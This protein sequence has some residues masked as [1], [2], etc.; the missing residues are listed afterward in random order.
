MTAMKIVRA[1]GTDE[2]HRRRTETASEIYEQLTRRPIGPV[3]IFEDEQRRYA[4][5]QPLEYA[6]E[7]FEQCAGDDALSSRRVELGQQR[8]ELVPAGPDHRLEGCI[9]ER[10]MKRAQHLD[11][12]T[13]WQ[14]SVDEV[15]AIAD[16]HA[17]RLGDARDELRQ[18]SRFADTRLAGHEYGLRALVDDRRFPDLLEPR[19]LGAATDE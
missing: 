14:R 10:A 8:R 6:E 12:R 3:E 16:E 19:Q 13:Q 17:G 2:H 18:E 4:L 15:E 5:G 9:V 1:V 11:D 7:L